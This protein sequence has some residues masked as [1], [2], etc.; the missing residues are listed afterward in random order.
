MQLS[1]FI[2]SWS[3]RMYY[4]TYYVEQRDA[5]YAIFI[6]C[7]LL[8]FCTNLG[9]FSF[10]TLRVVQQFS[11]WRR[12]FLFLGYV[13]SLLQAC[14]FWNNTKIHMFYIITFLSAYSVIV[15]VLINEEYNMNCVIEVFTQDPNT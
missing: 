3:V 14:I 6:A 10:N 15:I 8:R 12:S 5:T 2:Y 9:I 1:Q 13:L 4:G 7:H 11:L